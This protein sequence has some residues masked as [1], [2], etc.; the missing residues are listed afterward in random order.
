MLLAMLPGKKG[1]SDHS[2]ELFRGPL[3]FQDGTVYLQPG[4]PATDQQ[5]WYFPQLLAG[6]EGAS[7]K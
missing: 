6:M 7:S 3:K 1:L 2:I 5:I 4:E